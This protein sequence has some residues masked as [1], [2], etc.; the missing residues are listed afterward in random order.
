[1]SK[2]KSKPEIQC[3]VDDCPACGYRNYLKLRYSQG[4]MAGNSYIKEHCG[5]CDYEF[6]TLIV[7]LFKE[8]HGGEY[9]GPVRPT[10]EKP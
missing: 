3:R 5:R 6:G 8:H 4:H 9:T 7:P 2:V 10:G 1:M